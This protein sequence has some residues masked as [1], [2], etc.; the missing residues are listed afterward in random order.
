VTTTRTAAEPR[1]DPAGEPPEDPAPP[2]TSGA[3]V[4]GDRHPSPAGERIFP[5]RLP[6]LALE[7]LSV[8]VAAWAYAGYLYRI[9]DASLRV[10]LYPVRSDV[11]LISSMVKTITER[12]WYTSNPRLGAP[13][14]QQFYDFPHGG[15]TVQLA[16]IKVITLFVKDFGLTMNLY[17]MSGFGV[18]AVVTFLVLR[19]LRFG[20]VISAIAAL[21]YTFLP[22][23][24]AHAEYHLYRS[25]YYSAPLACLLLVWAQSWRARFLVD[26]EPPAGTRFRANLRWRRVVAAGAICALIAG[27]ETMTTSFTM[28]LLGSAALVSAIRW[29]EPARLLVSGVMVA[30]ILGTFLVLNF[31]TL[32]YYRTHG[33]NDLAARRT[34]TESELYG[35]KISRLVLPVGGHRLE[36]FTDVAKKSQEG[37]LVRSEAGQNLGVI[38]T[39]GFLGAIYG[40]LALGLRRTGRRDPR[41]PHDRG[42]LS[43]HASLVTMLALLFGTIGGFSILLALAGFSQVRVWNR[44]SLFIAF[45]SMV[46]VA[47]WFE[48][49]AGWVRRRAPSSPRPILGAL[50]VAVLAFGLWD[51]VT[52]T[53]RPPELLRTW[54]GDKAFVQG[55]EDRMPDGA[56]V[57][58]LPILAF[59]ESPPPNR[60]SDYDPLIGFLHDHGALRWSY[61]SIKG[62]PDADW[63]L[64]LRDR[65]GPVGALP[66]L[67]GLGF[68]GLWVDTYGYADGG[69]EIALIKQTIGVEPFRSA[70]GRFL[71]FDLRPYRQH[72]DMTDAEL[73]ATAKRVLEVTPPS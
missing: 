29:R 11:T 73:R 56:A 8:A 54:E 40:A 28:V 70:N 14:G 61:G 72:L 7:A 31:P 43:E 59:P 45:F 66:S 69:K 12:G 44:I 3:T 16:A 25:T 36:A 13:F 65:I 37:S 58:Q 27:T 71:F 10:P 47:T 15:E 34:V 46:L 62:R 1:E 4:A 63:Q 24:F 32:N 6:R 57:F 35:L 60:M 53:Q 22:Y 23:H 49:L 48:R 21:I 17:Y 41:P 52:I 51:G 33:T 9:W 39:A 2:G 42:S 50:A 55:I 38:G 64:R 19:H 67:L 20:Y 68:T 26:P 18:L 30:A 5:V